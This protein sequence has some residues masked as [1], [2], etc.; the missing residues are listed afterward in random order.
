[1]SG[2]G[3]LGGAIGGALGGLI[4]GERTNSS[5]E[6]QQRVQ[7]KFESEQAQLQRDFNSAEAIAQ[8]SWSA[9]EAVKSRSFNSAEAL[10]SR[11]FNSAEASKN[12]DFEERMSNSAVQRRMAD[13]K[14]AG[15]NPILAG[16][17]D[18][19]S[20]AGS[21]LPG[22]AASSPIPS[23]AA[24]QSS[25]SPRGSMAPVVDSIEKAFNATSVVSSIRR[26]N[27]EIKRID[28]DTR[29]IGA[30]YRLTEDQRA[31][32]T[33]TIYKLNAE[34]EKVVEQ[35]VGI[36]YENALKKILTEFY[37]DK[38][39]AYIA[40]DLGLDAKVFKDIITFVLGKGRK[41]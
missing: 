36:S 33:A 41:K 12:R 35:N 2:W 26:N 19:S 18:A 16:K 1:M 39:F 5:N 24:A 31:Q 4:G 37:T 20:P 3:A 11:R 13:L 30:K 8:R 32:I 21:V 27:A 6:H 10:L 9:D 34:A 38:E 28:E 14:A 29:Y 25:A 15:I 17:F 23:G 40:K 7:H 22:A